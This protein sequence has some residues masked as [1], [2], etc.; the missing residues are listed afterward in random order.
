MPRFEDGSYGSAKGIALIAKVL[1][2]KCS[3][4]YTRVAVGN[5]TIPED[6]TPKTMGEPAGYIMDGMIASVTNPIDGECQ[7]TVQ[8][9]SAQVEQ[10]FYAT[11]LVLYASDPDEGEIPYTYLVLENEPE[12]IRPSSSIVGKLAQEK[13]VTEVVFDRGG[14]LYHGRVKALADAAREAGLKF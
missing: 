7:V 12:W 10:G 13:G 2:G 5:G 8:V 14:H 4:H 9:N 3:M 6:M 1:A 11:G